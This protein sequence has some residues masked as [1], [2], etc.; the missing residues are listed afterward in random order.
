M[1]TALPGREGADAQDRTTGHPLDIRRTTDHAVHRGRGVVVGGPAQQRRQWHCLRGMRSKCRLRDDDPRTLVSL[2]RRLVRPRVLPVLLS[3]RARRGTRCV[4]PHI[5]ADPRGL[6]G[7]VHQGTNPGMRHRTRCRN[8]N[9]APARFRV[10]GRRAF[11]SL[12]GTARCWR[13]SAVSSRGACAAPTH[14]R[15]SP[16]GT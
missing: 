12:P 9:P 7:R 15:P 11:G 2:E 3:G 14:C 6:L 5:A 8:G 10:C 1:V 4:S 16:P 13:G